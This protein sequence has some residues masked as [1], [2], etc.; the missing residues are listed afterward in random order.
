MAD[1]RLTVRLPPSL[2]EELVRLAE[3]EMREPRWQAAVLIAD[4]LAIAADAHRQRQ[5]RE[6]EGR[7]S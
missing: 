2:Y 3:R 4:G 1:R 7:Q 5:R 6:A